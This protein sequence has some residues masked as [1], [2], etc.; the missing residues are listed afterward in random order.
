MENTTP[1][2]P[3]SGWKT[4]PAFRRPVRTEPTAPRSLRF[5]PPTAKHAFSLVELSIVLVILGLLTGGIL[6]GQ[7]L[8]RAAELR[9]VVTELQKYQ[10]A[11][12]SF[13]DK[14]FALPGDMRNASS[15]WG[16]MTNCGAASPSGTGTQTC[17]G[18][19]DG[20]MNNPP[21][22][23]QTG[24]VF[25]F[26]QH[27]ANAGL[28]E[29]TYTGISGPGGGGDVVI[30]TNVP[31]SKLGNSGWSIWDWGDLSAGSTTTL[32]AANYRNMLLFGEKGPGIT[33]KENMTPEE[34]WNIDTKIDD[35]LPARGKA[36]IRDRRDCAL[37]SNGA[38]LTT[39]SADSLKLDAK[40]NLS[41][42]ATECSFVFHA[43][44]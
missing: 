5:C 4:P 1:H 23:S 16:T 41:L 11:V 44:M 22:S 7:S 29:G 33:E 9:S 27:L 19:G 32:F 39:S 43:L 35:G 40:Y 8:I 15:F 2:P 3:C 20:I 36:K 14:Y 17:N 10:T 12:R 25:A 26:W 31:A 42:N 6:T 34:A 28:I 18:N 37:A 30:A 38:P 21:V 13:Q 24:E